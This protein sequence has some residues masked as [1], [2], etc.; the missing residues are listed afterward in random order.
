MSA[1]TRFAVSVALAASL[2]AVVGASAAPHGASGVGLVVALQQP[3]APAQAA[4][5]GYEPVSALPSARE[6]LPAAPLL[7]AAYAF[8]WLMLIGY[9]WS[10]WRRLAV[11]ERELQ[12]VSR[13]VEEA[14]RR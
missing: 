11:V 4:P 6:Q 3:P 5:E 7:M 10:I 9:L 14:G 12:S 2:M 1:H 8:V 13:R